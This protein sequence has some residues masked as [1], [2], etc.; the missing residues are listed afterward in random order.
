MDVNGNG[1]LSLAEIDK[2]VVEGL[3][4][5]ALGCTDFNHKPV[6][7]RAYKAADKSGDGFIERSEFTK[8]LHFIVYFTNC[9]RL[10]E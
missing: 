4:G 7:I 5:S 2:A 6:L 10:F 9:W 8:L 1:G 3:L